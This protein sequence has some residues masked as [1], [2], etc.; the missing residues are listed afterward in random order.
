L[1]AEVGEPG[2][3]EGFGF[4]VEEGGSGAVD[5]LDVGQ[6]AL[7]SLGL[8]DDGELFEGEVVDVAQV[9]GGEVGSEEVGEEGAGEVADG[10]GV[11]EVS[12]VW[13]RV[14]CRHG[15]LKTGGVGGSRGRRGGGGRYAHRSGQCTTDEPGPPSGSESAEVVRL[16]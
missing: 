15:E 12:L 8:E 9:E 4:G 5:A 16:R 14:C 1:A 13:R 2:S 10:V 6:G 11:G 7:E 3:R